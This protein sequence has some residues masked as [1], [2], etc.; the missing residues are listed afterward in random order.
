MHVYMTGRSASAGAS[1]IEAIK[2]EPLPAYHTA[3]GTLDFLAFD[4]SDMRDVRTAGQSLASRLTHLDLLFHVAG[5]VHPPVE[6]KS[7]QGVDLALATNTLGPLLLTQLLTPVLRA[8]PAP[9]VTWL[10]TLSVDLSAPAGGV[11]LAQHLD[12]APTD[13]A[14]QYAITKLATWY[15]AAELPRQPGCERIASVAVNPGNIASGAQ[16]HFPWAVRAL[17]RPIFYHTRCGALGVLWCGLSE[18][19]TS[20]RNG[21]YVVPFG[22]WHPGPRADLV[23]NLKRV[24]EGGDGKAREVWEWCERRIGGLL[25]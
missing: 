14:L 13:P 9:R 4:I 2:A 25:A 5:V 24:E 23:K 19:V 3:G 8:A 12:T 1:A 7:P 17:L 18:E 11:N 15:F 21:G 20:A 10:T 16:R 22:R 6:L